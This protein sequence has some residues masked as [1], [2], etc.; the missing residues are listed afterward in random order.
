MPLRHQL[1]FY[2]I[3]VIL[4]VIFVFGWN[5]YRIAHDSLLI[6][7][8]HFLREHI[9]QQIRVL[10]V[11]LAT[12][13]DTFG[14]LEQSLN[15]LHAGNPLLNHGHISVITN[16]QGGPL[17]PRDLKTIFD[18]N[19]ED[20]SIALLVKS[21]N[22]EG[23]L[24]ISNEDYIWVKSVIPSSPYYLVH[25]FQSKAAQPLSS[26]AT[27]L[28]VTALVVLWVAV[29]IALIISTN[30]S[31][32]LKAQSDEI[33]YQAMHDSLT[34][35][36]NRIWLQKV[37]EKQIRIAK[38][39]GRGIALIMMD[40]DRFKEINDTLGHDV[41][42]AL[43]QEVG[44][45]LQE[46]LWKSDSIARM[47]GDEFALLLPIKNESHCHLALDKIIKEM[48][49]AFLLNGIP[50][51]INASL[52]VAVYPTHGDDAKNLI[53]CAEVAMY[54]AKDSGDPYIIYDPEKDPHSLK[55]LKL[56]GDLRLASSKN[57]LLLYYQPKMDM[58]THEITGVEALIRWQHPEF[59]FVP[60]DEFIPLAEQSGA[61]KPVTE[62]VLHTAIDQCT[63]WN[64]AGIALSVSVNLSARMLH[65]I[66][67]PEQVQSILQQHDLPAEK[68]ELE[69]T[70]TAI[71][72][73]PEKALLILNKLNSIGIRLAIDDFGT[74]YTSLSHLKQL[75]V[76]DI[77]VDKSF[78]MDMLTDNN[79]AVIVQSIINLAHSM[80]RTVI[81]EGVENRK[82]LTE[83]S[84]LGCDTIQGYYLSRPLPA[85]EF[86]GW[87]KSGS[88]P[89]DSELKYYIP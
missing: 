82:T 74:G 89:E 55:R 72:M 36:P 79:D 5:A 73:D 70:E 35:L 33:E 51:E 53:R 2:F 48:E 78:V 56:T 32:K 71:M 21:N 84:H 25:I 24:T 20:F 28:M 54:L 81:A 30:I 19:I 42:D 41:G 38:K 69:I 26:L 11:T 58:K 1:L 45:S 62:W 6:E 65:D 66:V 50:L 37:L 63:K 87:L 8:K 3:T 47:G 23:T 61:I 40:L 9:R 64:R 29:W 60:P 86:E 27:R 67:L 49:T 80:G 14:Q 18:K 13:K 39:T 85:N 68:L 76:D 43:L 31:R 10:S 57:Q 16:N 34:S 12:T 22:T 52:G 15:I 7:E 4:A 75:P 77:K 17:L 59:G 83:L 46:T 88:L 44:R